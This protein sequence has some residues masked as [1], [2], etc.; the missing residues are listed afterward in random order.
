MSE[1]STKISN[2]YAPADSE[3]KFKTVFKNWLPIGFK[4]GSPWLETCS[5]NHELGTQPDWDSPWSRTNSS[6][7]NGYSLKNYANVLKSHTSPRVAS[8]SNEK[9]INHHGFNHLQSST[10]TKSCHLARKKTEEK[11]PNFCGNTR[12]SWT[13]DFSSPQIPVS[14][15]PSVAPG[16][17]RRTH[18]FSRYG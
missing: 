10:R 5:Y 16:K 14:S 12:K 4:L 7:N 3:H 1:S 13:Q 2:F 17:K 9:K 8:S 15:F 6:T 18:L 11:P